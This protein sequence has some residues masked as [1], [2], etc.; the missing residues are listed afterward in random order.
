MAS[1]KLV[2]VKR[3]MRSRMLWAFPLILCL[4]VAICGAQKN[5]KRTPANQATATKAILAVLESQVAAWNR[6][7]LEGF[8][9]G[10]R[11]S[12][13]LSFYSG[14][15]KT[16]GW[17]TT[18]ERY[19]NRYQSAGHEMGHLDFTDLEVET[20]GPESAFVRGHWNLKLTAGEQGGLFTLIFR[21]F[22]DGWKIIHDH[23]SA[24]S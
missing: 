7:D 24:S 17:N 13:K 1:N 10:Y 6:H 4:A 21:K 5:S 19:R 16:S 3:T 20:L 2:E 22:S 14:G 11:N 12:E 23:T 18:L 15:I 9:T 8:M